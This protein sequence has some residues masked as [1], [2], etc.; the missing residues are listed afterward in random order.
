MD[1]INR[2]GSKDPR[3]I[4]KALTETDIPGN[5][6]ALPW[7]GVKFDPKTHQ[8]IYSRVMIIQYQNKVQKVVWPW[9]MAE[10]EVMWK[11]PPWDK[12]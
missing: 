2:A 6:L 9:S 1:A 12:R 11:L 7:D 5:F 8:N 4:Q 3:A 10:A